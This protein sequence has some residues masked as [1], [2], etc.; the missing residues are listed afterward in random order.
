MRRTHSSSLS[1]PVRSFVPSTRDSVESKRETSCSL[2]ISSEKKATRFPAVTAACRAIF[3]AKLVLPMPGRAPR[4]I[5]SV[6][7]RPV[8]VSSS[9]L[10][11]VGTPRYLS[12]SGELRR[13][14]LS[15]SSKM[16]SSTFWRPCIFFPRR[17]SKMR[18]SAESNRVAASAAPFVAS[19]M[20]PR[21]VIMS[22]R[23]SYLSRTI[24]A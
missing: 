13:S 5:K 8:M 10:N 4:R 6:R 24:F 20:M 12:A 22:V 3:K 15:Y 14:S 19:S 17:M 11:P 7:F 18:C 21:A 23:T 16:I 9:S 1:F 2:L